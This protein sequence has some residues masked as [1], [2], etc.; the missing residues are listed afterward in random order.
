MN[1][2]EA[3]ERLEVSASLVYGLLSSGKLKC[4]RI[5]MGRGNYRISEEQLAAY[6]KACESAPITPALPSPVRPKLRYLRLS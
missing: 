5:G 3:A 2:K 1:V 4:Y 6:L